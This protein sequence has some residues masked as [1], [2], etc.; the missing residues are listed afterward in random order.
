M[1][2]LKKEQDRKIKEL[3]EILKKTKQESEAEQPTV[4]KEIKILKSKQAN[5][6]VIHQR[7]MNRL[8][9]EHQKETDAIRK[10]QEAIKNKLE[11]EKK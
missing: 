1:E 5:E 10:K 8:A 6:L 4:E 11:E 9:E 2:K 7:E 3:D